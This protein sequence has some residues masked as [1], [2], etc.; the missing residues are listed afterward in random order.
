MKQYPSIS[1]SIVDK[2]ILAQPKYDGSNI[3]AEYNRKTGFSKFGSRN[4]LLGD[5]HPF[6]GGA[7]AKFR[8]KYERDLTDLFKKERLEQVVC[9][10]EY[11]GA[12][13]FAGFHE[14]DDP[15]EVKLFDLDIYKRGLIP[16]RDFYD[17]VG[18]LDVAPILYEG[19]PNDP[20]VQ[21]VKNSTLEGMPLEGVICKGLPLKR[22]Y[23]P[24][25][26][27]VKS[28]AWIERLKATREDWEKYV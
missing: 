17:L 5:D 13:S 1:G 26:F 6:L 28:I 3:R 15:H 16:P 20:F 10:F 11:F 27:K 12:R 8:E 4:V 22:G 25:M 23:P 18:H 24:V 2:P 9:F 14:A 21:S 7:I 19:H